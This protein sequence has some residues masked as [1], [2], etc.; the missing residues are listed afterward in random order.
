M[1][2]VGFGVQGV[3]CQRF[4]HHHTGTGMGQAGYYTHQD[5]QFGF[6]RQLVSIC[7]HVV[8]LL[9]GRRFE[10]WNHG[11]LAIETRVLLV[12]R[13]VHGRVIGSQHH[14]ASVHTC[15]GG[16]DKGVGGHVHS[17]MLHTNQ[18]TLAG[19]SHT[20]GSFHGGLLIR[21]PTATHLRCMTLDKFGYFG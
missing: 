12:L 17:H 9:L 21:T 8:S 6:F 5:R 16:V 20:E 18:G 1:S 11:E 7:H 15:N 19:I 4:T 13:R 10:D 2:T 14:Q 3:L